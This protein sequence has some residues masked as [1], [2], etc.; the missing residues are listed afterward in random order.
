MVFH[1]KNR[2]FLFFL[3][4]IVIVVIFESK[5]Y[6]TRVSISSLPEDAAVV[7]LWV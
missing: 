1:A 2:L 3:L 6:N 4:V 7:R 5:I